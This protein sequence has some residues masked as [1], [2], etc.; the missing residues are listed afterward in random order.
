MGVRIQTYKTIFRAKFY[1]AELALGF[2]TYSLI[3]LAITSANKVMLVTALSELLVFL[4]ILSSSMVL[5]VATFIV[6]KSSKPSGY[7]GS[8]YSMLASIFG[9]FLVSCG[10]QAPL[11][12]AIL[13]LIGLNVVEA[14]WFMSVIANYN[15]YILILFLLINLA[16]LYYYLGKASEYTEEGKKK[17]LGKVFVKA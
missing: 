3:Y 14:T 7:A 17:M 4:L 8:I 13:Y 11:L 16:L 15:N 10:C 9:S 6:R 2:I 1:L 5:V 12:M